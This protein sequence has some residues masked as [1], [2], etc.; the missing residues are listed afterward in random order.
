[1]TAPS[2]PDRLGDDLS[3]PI[4]A[5]LL[6]LVGRFRFATTRQLARVTRPAYRSSR[7]ALRQTAR[8][9]V[10]LNRAGLVSHLERRVG[11][12]QG[13]SQAAVWAL[14]TRGH[15]TLTGSR[16]RQRPQLTS[17]T[18]LAHLL[19]V[20]ETQVLITE[21][22]RDLPDTTAQVTG[23]PHSWRRFLGPH[24]QPVSVRP[25]LHLTVKSE[26]YRDDYFLEIDRATEN[27]ARVIATCWTY[28]RYQRTGT[29]QQTSGAFPVVVWLVPSTR[30][31]EQLRRHLGAEPHLRADLFLVITPDELPELLRSG[32]PTTT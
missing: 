1:M 11:G 26:Q 9:L 13:G 12:W 3:H 2:L 31:R 10:S 14:T 17:T 25:D 5:E 29:E 30:R 22:V 15:R 19:A 24:G 20:T 8:H 6:T 28:Q 27:P 16:S 21:T 23:E 7:S 18:F 4:H 32:P